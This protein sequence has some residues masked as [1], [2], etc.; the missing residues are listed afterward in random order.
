MPDSN[1]YKV[2]G[3]FHEIL[4]GEDD[5][6]VVIRVHIAIEQLLNELLGLLCSNF[7]S[8]EDQ[9][10]IDFF[11]KGCLAEA[12]GLKP[13]H[14]KV[15]QVLGKLRNEFAHKPEMKLGK[16]NVSNLYEAFSSNGKAILQDAFNRVRKQKPKTKVTKS[17]KKLPPK[18]QFI[19]MAV[20][21]QSMLR[22]E[23]ILKKDDLKS[24]ELKFRCECGQD[25]LVVLPNK[26]NNQS[27]TIEWN[28]SVCEKKY[29]F[30]FKFTRK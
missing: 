14:R 29:Q 10:D 15:L 18:D 11:E 13:E 22:A 7:N 26:F 27:K 25:N 5:L 19:L 6:G 28:C 1:T 8:F 16:S 21:I 20:T 4:Q 24:G 30:E 12:L 23:I 17:F 3:K 9:A 2:D